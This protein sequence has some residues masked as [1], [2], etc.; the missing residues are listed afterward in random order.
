MKKLLFLVLACLVAGFSFAQIKAEQ[1]LQA[2]GDKYPTERIF[3]QYDKENYIAGETIYFKTYVFSDFGLSDLSTNLYVEF[4]DQQ[5]Q[6]LDKMIL[7]LIM[8]TGNGTLKLKENMPE[9]IYHIRAYTL[10]SLNF[11]SELPYLRSIPV[12]N[13]ASATRLISKPVQWAAYAFPES[14]NLLEGV[15]HKVAVRLFTKTHLPDSWQAVLMKQGSTQALLNF[16][17]QNGEVGA[18]HLIPEA[19]AIYQ[20]HVKDNLGNQQTINLP[21]VLKSGVTMQVAQ[22]KEEITCQII[23]KG[24]PPE[25]RSYKLIGQMSNGLVYQAKITRKDSVVIARI[26]MNQ[27]ATGILHLTLIDEKE[28]AVA[29]RLFFVRAENAIS[30]SVQ[31][32]TLSLEKRGLNSF[33]F[34]V[35]TNSIESYTAFVTDIS[36]DLPKENLQSAIALKDISFPVNKPAS[37]FSDANH[38]EALDA[39]MMTEKW[40]WFQWQTLTVTKLPEPR[41]QPD[42]YL[43]Y[44]GTVFLGR[45]MQLNK[46][47]NLIFKLE[48]STI[49]FTE[50]RTD[51]TASFHIEGAQFLDTATIYYQLDSKRPAANAIKALFE[52][53]NTFQRLHEELPNPA[54]TVVPRKPK[55]SVPAFLQRQLQAYFNQAKVDKRY[56]QLQE[57]IVKSKIK[58]ATEALNKKLSSSAFRSADERVFDF[59]DPRT[60]VGGYNNVID[61]ARVRI[62]GLGMLPRYRGG[63]ISIYVDEMIADISYASM[64]S[65]NDVAMVKFVSNPGGLMTGNGALLIY[66]KRGGGQT[67]LFRGMPSAKLAG[68]RKPLPYP[69]V[70]HTAEL[71]KSIDNDTRQVLYWTPQ[72]VP[73]SAGQVRIRFYNNDITTQFRIIVMGISKEGRMIYFEQAVPS[74]KPEL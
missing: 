17:S 1:A 52:S 50:A 25:N 51:S 71:Y 19:S 49:I 23:F 46:A 68:Y 5:K 9:G 43:S 30:V 42:N 57:V 41:Y 56:K 58:S 15:A 18:F 26:P 69:L 11:G 37:Y 13:P 12:Y 65:I 28:K 29:E 70:D 27:L 38:S 22:V 21:A 4:Y 47:L 31:T 66:T 35:D 10:W 64:I 54:Y 14:G 44:T 61:W 73:D 6:L 7:P 53:N 16:S 24:L 72:L 62:P 32:D 60:N 59:S 63:A 8:G 2:F 39:L 33:S 20:V 48:D 45:K 3:L 74:R 34:S 55:D 67:V 40:R 36:T